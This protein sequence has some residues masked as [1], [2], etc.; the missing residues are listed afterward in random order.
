M[1]G[2]EPFFPFEAEGFIS[3]GVMQ[4]DVCA[5]I[6]MHALLSRPDCRLFATDAGEANVNAG[7][8]AEAGA[9]VADLYQ[10]ARALS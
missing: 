6:A 10:K 9:Q 2:Q 1:K 8:I 3:A 7:D 4:R 5:F